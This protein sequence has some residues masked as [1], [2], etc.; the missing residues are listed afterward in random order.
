MSFPHQ[1]HARA[2]VVTTPATVESQVTVERMFSAA[3]WGRLFKLVE[4]LREAS[5]GVSLP[6]IAVLGSQ[7][8]G[9][10]SVLEAIAGIEFLPKGEGLVT[11]L[12]LEVRLVKARGRPYFTFDELRGQSFTEFDK[13]RFIIQELTDR[14]AGKNKA[15]V[16]KPLTLSVFAP[17]CPDLCLIDL[18]GITRVAL[19]GS[20]QPTDIE[21]VTKE[22]AAKYCMDQ[23]TI[24][25][26]VVPA[27]A[28]LSTSDALQ[29]ALSLDP[30]GERTLGVLTKVD[31]MDRGTNAR[32]ILQ[33]QEVAL[34]LGFV[35]VR[36][37][38]A[39]ELAARVDLKRA[40]QEEIEFFA[41]HSIYGTMSPE[42]FG[43]ES[44]VRRLTGLFYERVADALPKIR[45]EVEQKITSGRQRL[46]ALGT[47]VPTRSEDKLPFLA[48]IFANLA[49]ALRREFSGRYLRGTQSRSAP[50]VRE[51]FRG[52]YS[53]MLGQSG[54]ASLDLAD[55][56]IERAIMLHED[57]TIG[58]F[59]SKDAFLYLV[60]PLLRRL[61]EPALDLL[62]S[63]GFVIEESVT[64]IV[65]DTLKRFP[66]LIGLVRESLMQV[67]AEEREKTKELVLG[68]VDS[69]ANYVFTN[70]SEYLLQRNNFLL[71]QNVRKLEDPSKAIVYEMRARIE[72]YYSVVLRNSRES[73]P[74][75]VGRF[76]L[77]KSM[78]RC[79]QTLFILLAST[80]GIVGKVCEPPAISEERAKI[81]EELSLCQQTLELLS[82]DMELQ[83]AKAAL[84]RGSPSSV[85]ECDDRGNT[86][87]AQ[88]PRQLYTTPGALMSDENYMR[89]KLDPGVKHHSVSDFDSK[90]MCKNG[91]GPINLPTIP[92]EPKP[93]NTSLFAN[94]ENLSFLRLK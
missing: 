61:R 90:F 24:I 10:S 89:V 78:E 87:N 51:L 32:R 67:L 76:F 22:I 34:R 58:G 43:V 68:V 75:L 86:S 64:A 16:S 6:R 14:F 56:D 31:L 13:L 91:L 55:K 3:E 50:R 84:R 4:R 45:Y 35:A 47:E 52:L 1:L 79:E 57:D 38:G 19:R 65:E 66:S 15:I 41:R 18:P 70:D 69:E 5:G 72:C 83:K 7:S 27:N 60:Q 2:A 9:K 26:C 29:M 59:P 25:L 23:N 85:D 37:R 48:Q 46:A 82:K 88:P 81:N 49:E 20:D 63:V 11:R 54:R 36:N 73:I 39:Q 94:I 33:G 71:G 44:L 21:R 17:N 77:Q 30:K 40:A 93:K 42:F 74:K 92:P 8:A 12:P 53:E 62:Q 28:D 80:P